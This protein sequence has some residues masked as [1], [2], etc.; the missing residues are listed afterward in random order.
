M[1]TVLKVCVQG[2]ERVQSDSSHDISEPLIDDTYG[3]GSQSL[4]NLMITGRATTYVWDHEQD[5]G[6]L[7]RFRFIY[8]FTKFVEK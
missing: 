6:G 2:L 5:V 3:Y 8:I 1:I 7:S 4:I